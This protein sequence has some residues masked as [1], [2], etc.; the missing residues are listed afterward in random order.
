MGV[1]TYPCPKSYPWGRFKKAYE[2]LNLRA[3]KFSPV[4]K[5]QIFQRMGKI[6]CVEFQREP[7]IFHTKYFL[8]RLKYMIFIQH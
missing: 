8:H 4:N 7:L 2:L 1:I 5:M 6:F 3:I